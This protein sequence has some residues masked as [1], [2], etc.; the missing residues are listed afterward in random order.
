MNIYLVGG[1]VRDRLL[2]R[3]SQDRDWVVVGATPQ[4]MLD[5][6]FL[7]VGADFPVF[8]D[9]ASGEEYALARQERKAGDGYHGFQ[10]NT[11]GVTLEEDLSRRDLTI[12]A[13]AMADN[14]RLIDP[15]NGKR[16]LDAKVLRHVGPAFAEDPVRI[17]RVLRFLARFGSDWSVAPE[18]WALLRAMVE[19]GSASHLVAERVWKEISRAL[20]EP[21]PQMLVQGLHDLRLLEQPAFEAY[22][23]AQTGEALS[24]LSRAAERGASLETRFALAFPRDVPKPLPGVTNRAWRMARLA[25]THRWPVAE[26][27]AR[28]VETLAAADFHRDSSL[29]PDLVAAWAAQGHPV[30]VAE[31]VAAAVAQ[32]DTKAITS[33]MAPGPAVAQAIRDARI[34]AVHAVRGC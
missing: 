20:M 15:F 22:R 29:W 30:Q 5:R 33:S 17:L 13:M 14:D 9:Q 21:H 26:T 8:L 7:Q 24:S 23:T 31:Q 28:W 27:A 6:G 2:G 4:D 1:A 25:C 19:D 16:D 11:A 12:N 3:E 10:T 18:T 32:I 34:S